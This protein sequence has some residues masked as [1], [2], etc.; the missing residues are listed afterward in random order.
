MSTGSSSEY[1]ETDA[2]GFFQNISQEEEEDSE[3]DSL[4]YYPYAYL[5]KRSSVRKGDEEDLIMSR[6]R[7][8][9][10]MIPMSEQ[11]NK[12]PSPSPELITREIKDVY[13][14]LPLSKDDNVPSGTPIP[15]GSLIKSTFY[16]SERQLSPMSARYMM[17]RDKLNTRKQD[18]VRRTLRSSLSGR[19]NEPLIEY[20]EDS[21]DSET[22]LRYRR[23]S[24]LS[25]KSCS[26]DRWVSPVYPNS[27]TQR[28]SRSLDES[29]RISLGDDGQELELKHNNEFLYEEE[30]EASEVSVN[31]ISKSP[32]QSH[33]ATMGSSLE[34]SH[35]H[36]AE[37]EAPI[38]MGEDRNVAGSQLSLAE[39]FEHDSDASSRTSTNTG[40]S[41]SHLQISWRHHRAYDESEE[42]L[43][44]P[45][46]GKASELSLSQDS[47][48]EDI[49]RERVLE[50]LRQVPLQQ[51]THSTTMSKS[52]V[53][54]RR[55]SS[56][57]PMRPAS[58]TP[59]NREVLQRHSSVPALKLK[60]QSDKSGK[61]GFMKIFRR[62]SWTPGPSSSQTEGYENKVED[63]SSAEQKTP[64]LTLRKKIRASASNIT[65]LF[66]RQSSKERKEEKQ[67]I[68][69]IAN[70]IS[71]K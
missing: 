3:E 16:N 27:D 42:N 41:L 8:G 20:V 65:K 51:R 35:S 59:L 46:L 25:S 39:S 53:A 11:A 43:V 26:L 22:A 31:R 37:E 54:L 62:K 13:S 4:E 9:A 40:Q 10:L 44:A 48:D 32:S 1:D 66:T 67:G 55:S 71:I 19:L 14:T 68:T 2:W 70:V 45:S 24:T 36:I 52:S 7:R 6:V 64:L 63:G 28:R 18:R 49:L 29:S 15:R 12:T 34:D 21:P 30:N 17:L 23:S 69:Q 38:V 60:P 61:F 56:A 58:E 57:I 50:N 47:D 33:K 5:P